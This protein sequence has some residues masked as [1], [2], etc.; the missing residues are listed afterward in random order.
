[1][2]NGRRLVLIHSVWRYRRRLLV[3]RGWQILLLAVHG[4]RRLLI[5][6]SSLKVHA[7]LAKLLRHV[8]GTVLVGP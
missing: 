5:L 1:M 6:V 4:A 7:V 8:V 2:A 3:A